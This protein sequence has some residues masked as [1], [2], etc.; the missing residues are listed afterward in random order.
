MMALVE[1]FW[2]SLAGVPK[3]LGHSD[4]FLSYHYSNCSFCPFSLTAPLSPYGR[5][6]EPTT[7]AAVFPLVFP[8]AQKYGGSSK[9]KLK[10][11]TTS[12]GPFYLFV[13]YCLYPCFPL[14]LG[15]GGEWVQYTRGAYR[16]SQNDTVLEHFTGV[17]HWQRDNLFF[18]TER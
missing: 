7:V 13:Y 5:S 9:S 10:C 4:S 17:G 6:D 18:L 16:T 1:E 2:P 12:S 3:S 15:S 8:L 11:H 14:W